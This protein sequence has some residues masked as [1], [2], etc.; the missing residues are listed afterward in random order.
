MAA[1]VA[2]LVNGRDLANA[3]VAA[4]LA[5]ATLTVTT[6]VTVTLPA[7]IKTKP[8][9]LLL[10]PKCSSNST[11]KSN[12][13]SFCYNSRSSRLIKTNF[14]SHNFNT[15]NNNSNTNLL[16]SQP[17]N[18]HHNPPQCYPQAA[19]PAKLNDAGGTAH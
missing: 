4:A 8:I 1:A 14:N 19:L 10:S 7:A 17:N 5:V 6:K 12:R 9:T 13:S 15:Y 11:F 3:A 16:R 2:N 18:R